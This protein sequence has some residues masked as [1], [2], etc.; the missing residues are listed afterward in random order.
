MKIT[1]VYTKTGDEE[2]QLAYRG[3]RNRRRAERRPRPAGLVH[4]GR[5]RQEPDL[6]HTAQPVHRVLVSRYGQ[7]KDPLG[8]VIHARPRR[9]G[10]AREG[11]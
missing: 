8:A 9:S 2:D 4:E 3:L 1:K 7:G 5:S 6:P 11:D 10:R